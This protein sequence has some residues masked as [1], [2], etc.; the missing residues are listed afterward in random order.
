MVPLTPPPAIVVRA[1]AR[2]TPKGQ[3]LKLALQAAA[4]PLV[5]ERTRMPEPRRGMRFQ[6]VSMPELSFDNADLNHARFHNVNLR[7]GKISDANLSDLE[8]QDAQ[9]GGAYIHDIGL[10]PKGSPA[11]VEG[12]EQRPLRFEACDLHGSTVK[13]CDLRSVQ[14]SG[15]RMQ[16]M[17]IDGISVEDLLAAYREKN[18]APGAGGGKQ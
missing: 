2:A 4:H 9:W 12:A 10:P 17:A 11:Y 6:N 8:I 18:G 15:C 7:N 5:G 16:G 14:I 13:N 1:V 3:A